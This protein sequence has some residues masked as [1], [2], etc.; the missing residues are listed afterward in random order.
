MTRV[1]ETALGLQPKGVASS[2]KV[3]PQTTATRE[4][5]GVGTG[6][7]DS[8][9]PP[10]QRTGR[11]SGGPPLRGPVCHN[12]FLVADVATATGVKDAMSLSAA[13]EAM[14]AKHPA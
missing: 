2:S 8:P 11:N 4:R 13:E 9:L 12:F 10:Q 14:E 6:A 3:P 1:A 5:H 7:S